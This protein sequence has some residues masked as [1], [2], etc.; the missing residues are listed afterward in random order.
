MGKVEVKKIAQPNYDDDR[1]PTPGRPDDAARKGK[2]Q[3][4][5][6]SVE[7][8]EDD[9]LVQR[10]ENELSESKISSSSESEFESEFEQGDSEEESPINSGYEED[11]DDYGTIGSE[12]SA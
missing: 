6:A 5:V 10:A 11:D 4:A 9:D 1:R 3:V 7:D 8:P 2:T 12:N